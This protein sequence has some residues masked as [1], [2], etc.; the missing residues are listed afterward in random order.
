MAQR[1]LGGRCVRLDAHTTKN[2]EARSFPFTTEIEMILKGQLAAHE[3]LKAAG[4]LCPFVFHRNG[5][6][7]LGRTPAKRLAVLA[8]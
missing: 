4:T 7:Q 6:G 1:R 3:R 2:G 5:S 8:S